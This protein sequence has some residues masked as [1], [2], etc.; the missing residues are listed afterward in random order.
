MRSSPGGGAVSLWF[1]VSSCCWLILLLLLLPQDVH[2]AKHP[3]KDG[4]KNK[5]DYLYKVMPEEDYMPIIEYTPPVDNSTINELGK[6][7]LMSPSF[8]YSHTGKA[9]V[10]RIVEFYGTF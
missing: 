9:A 1:L 10:A 8:L 3:I 5:A 2:A 6:P 4:H 7:E